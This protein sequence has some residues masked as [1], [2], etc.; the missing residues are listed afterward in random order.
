MYTGHVAFALGARGLRR[1][2]PLWLLVLAAQGA[3]WFELMGGQFGSKEH[4]EVWSHA[5]PGF[6]VAGGMTAA[7]TWAWRRRVGDA[8]T[9]LLLYISHPIADY[10]TGFKPF[11]RGGARVG[12]LLI[13]RP[14]V[15]FAIQG[16]LCVLGWAL[17]LRSLPKSTRHRVVCVLPLALLLFLQG[18]ADGVLQFGSRRFLGAFSQLEAATL[19]HSSRRLW[20]LDSR[21]LSGRIASTVTPARVAL[22]AWAIIG[23]GVTSIVS[24]GGPQCMVDSRQDYLV[25]GRS[26]NSAS[27][28]SAP[29]IGMMRGNEG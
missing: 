29:E 17:Y 11:W 25:M 21:S 24:W 8:L 5:F 18:L 26:G 22:H 1:D 12:L 28:W 13:E 10:I 16:S 9:I 27:R 20:T 14:G 6:L 4:S 2:M 15:D 3:D 7:L 23:Q 19:P